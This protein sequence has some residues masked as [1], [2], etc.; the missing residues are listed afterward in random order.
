MPQASYRVREVLWVT[1]PMELDTFCNLLGS[2]LELPEFH[3]D[4]ENV[5]EWGITIQV[6]IN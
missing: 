1:V 3:F 6:N 4:A 5:Y 2:K